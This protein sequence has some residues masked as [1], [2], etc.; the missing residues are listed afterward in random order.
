MN[1]DEK[2]FYLDSFRGRSIGIYLAPQVHPDEIESVVAELHDN[3]VL[4][5]LFASN[6]APGTP[7]MASN[8]TTVPKVAH[9]LTEAGLV[10]IQYS[11]DAD[12]LR[13]LDLACGVCASI[14]T[15]K[16]VIVHPR[17][18]LEDEGMR[19]SFVTARTLK[20]IVEEADELDDAGDETVTVGGWSVDELAGVLE[21][22]QSG[23]DSVNLSTPTGLADELFSYEGSG[24]LFS[25]LEYCTVKPLS[26]DDFPQALDLYERGENDG[27][28]LPRG[29]EERV[30]TLLGAVGAWFEGRLAGIASLETA[31]Y[32]EQGL[33]E[34]VGLYTITRY[35]GEG[36]GVRLLDYLAN[37]VT[38]GGL[39]GLFACARHEKAE[40]FFVRNGFEPVSPS[41]VP[42]AKWEGREGDKPKVFMRSL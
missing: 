9:E 17:G 24:T 31:R 29:P 3:A 8:S 34:V 14:R 39:K 32:A 5:V 6:F 40:E 37:Q 4:V 12:P 7:V 30:A 41:A 10:R 27:F 20:Q 42:A 33:A 36:V 16:L 23:V 21:V 26:I 38:R 15:H 19:D 18:G 28:L 1:R 11:S 22:L 2:E 25:R 13:T 35:H